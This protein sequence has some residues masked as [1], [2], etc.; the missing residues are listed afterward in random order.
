MFRDFNNSQHINDDLCAISS[1]DLQNKSIDQYV[2]QN[3]Y[4]TVNCEK[5]LNDNDIFLNNLNLH[6]RDGFGNTNSCGIDVDSKLRLSDMIHPRGKEQLCVRFYEACPN[7]NKGGLIPNIES[8]LKSAEDT[9]DIRDCIRTT[10]I[11]YNRWIPLPP[12]MKNNI[13]N[14]N[15]IVW[16]GVWGGDNTRDYRRDNK[17]LER[18]GFVNNGRAM[19]RKQ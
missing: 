19:V 4:P 18:C 13:Q 9:S 14:P 15:N 10:E 6:A 8:R 7:L 5:G 11:D 1:R 12:C 3:F 16:N 17:Y 2:L